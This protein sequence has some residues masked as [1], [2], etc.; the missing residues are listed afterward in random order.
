VLTAGLATGLLILGLVNP[1]AGLHEYVATGSLASP[2]AAPEV[3]E[4]QVLVNGLPALTDGGVVFTVTVT[5]LEAVQPF[6]AVFTT[7]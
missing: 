5:W 2:M 3:F 4:I 1:K 6:E 7:V